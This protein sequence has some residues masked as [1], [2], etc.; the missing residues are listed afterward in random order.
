MPRSRILSMLPLP[1]DVIHDGVDFAPTWEERQIDY[2]LAQIAKIRAG[3]DRRWIEEARERS[4]KAAA[5]I[6][7]TAKKIAL[8]E[9]RQKQ[10]D[11]YREQSERGAAEM[12]RLLEHYQRELDGGKYE[13]MVARADAAKKDMDR[14][15]VRLERLALLKRGV[16]RGR[17]GGFVDT[18][19]FKL[20]DAEFRAQP[21]RGKKPD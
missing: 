15:N 12:K 2:H 21:L 16:V 14:D 20:N 11:W 3:I 13:A 9:A 8:A 19:S 5:E 6:D 7:E 4:T 1:Y 17:R 10:L 18:T